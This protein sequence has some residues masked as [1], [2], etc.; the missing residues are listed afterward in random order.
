MSVILVENMREEALTLLKAKAVTHGQSLQAE[1]QGI[2]E[3]AATAEDHEVLRGWGM[4]F[5]VPPELEF[6]PDSVD[7]LEAY[8]S[9]CWP[10]AEG[11]HGIQVDPQMLHD[12]A[13]AAQGRSVPVARTEVDDMDSVDRLEADLE[14]FWPGA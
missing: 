10:N 2:L 13:L 11:W 5:P 7:Q 12:T 14:D 1:L 4:R 6:E 9:E 3:S 8:M